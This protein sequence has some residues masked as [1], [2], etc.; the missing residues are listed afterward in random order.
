MYSKDCFKRGFTWFR[1]L[2]AAALLSACSQ[3]TH[4]FLSTPSGGYTVSTLA[5]YFGVPGYIDGQVPSSSA[6]FS[7]IVALA[8]DASGNIYALEDTGSTPE[9]LI[10][11]ISS[12]GTVT[13]L[14]ISFPGTAGTPT[15][16]AAVPN[17]DLYVTT[18][19]A[20]L[21]QITPQGV[22]TTVSQAFLNYPSGIATTSAGDMYIADSNGSSIYKLDST[23]AQVGGTSSLTGGPAAIAVDSSGNCFVLEPNI[24]A[25]GQSTV[26]KWDTS[27]VVSTIGTYST[28]S[29]ALRGIATDGTF[30]Y[31]S[32]ANTSTILQIDLASPGSLTVW[33]GSSPGSLDALGTNAKFNQPSVMINDG[34]GGFLIADSGNDQ[35]RRVTPGAQ[36]TTVA[37]L[38]AHAGASNGAAITPV[39][40]DPE[41]VAVDQNLNVYI[42]DLNNNAVRKITPSG[43]VSTLAGS[44]YLLAPKAVVVNADGSLVYANDSGNNRI[45]KITS[46]GA[47]TVLYSGFTDEVDGIAVDSNGNVYVAHFGHGTVDKITPSGVLSSFYTSN[48]PGAVAVD[49]QDN[50]YVVS[51]NDT[52]LIKI[53]PQGQG[54]VITNALNHPTGVVIAADGDAYVTEAAN[55]VI[56]KVT[57]DGTTTTWMGSP[58]S[59]GATNGTAQSAKFNAPAGIAVDRQGTFYVADSGNDVIRK[60]S[61]R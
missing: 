43:V 46:A 22:V 41:G 30:V 39:F 33:A 51:A 49:A 10:R 3:P 18:D 8:A 53:T 11:K 24:P 52:S 50:V 35:I 26:Q 17:G 54:T 12:G 25:T 7:G 57:A 40:D 34:A 4:H 56:K 37:G 21:F 9:I 55:N 58:G 13:T 60:I 45:V 23:G 31:L 32:D 29:L 19:S 59:A 15:G 48:A 44:S 47:V 16:L 20:N 36:V 42:A 14:P 6:T 5:G 27:G 61:S 38:P 28:S 1:T 2:T